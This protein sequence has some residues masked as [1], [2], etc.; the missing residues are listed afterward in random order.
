[1]LRVAVWYLCTLTASC[2]PLLVQG[3]SHQDPLQ[4]V[5]ASFRA[6]MSEH[7]RLE[8]A[9]RF[10][11]QAQ[12]VRIIM[13]E[14]G[15]GREPPKDYTFSATMG[16]AQ[17]TAGDLG[18]VSVESKQA[19]WT[20][21]PKDHESEYT[22]AD[23]VTYARVPE[24][25]Q[26]VGRIVLFHGTSY[27]HL[28]NV[29]G[30]GVQPSGGSMMG[31][32]FYVSADPNVAK[33][34]RMKHPGSEGVVIEF[35]MKYE[36]AQQLQGR[37]FS[38]QHRSKKAVDFYQNNHGQHNDFCFP[39]ADSLRLLKMEAV[40][41][42]IRDVG[43]RVLT[44][45]RACSGWPRASARRSRCPASSQPRR[46]TLRSGRGERG[47]PMLP[48]IVIALLG[49]RGSTHRMDGHA[50]GDG[51]VCVNCMQYSRERFNRRRPWWACHIHGA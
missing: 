22:L 46:R 18:L 38:Y 47:A 5:L 50:V 26:D 30:K 11:L 24:S 36:D 14:A 27:Q 3:P 23:A 43:R 42:F 33:G 7:S 20:C 48:D 28:M 10:L 8:E 1:V 16:A 13:V 19:D 21:S 34:Y 17:V 29:I 12:S 40:H 45:R 37:R 25:E 51:R 41:I 35:S 32:G 31:K 39:K 49:R 2:S 44:T 9:T 4:K 15:G 6:T